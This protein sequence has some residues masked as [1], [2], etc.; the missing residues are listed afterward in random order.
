[1]KWLQKPLHDTM[2]NIDHILK[3]GMVGTSDTC[4]DRCTMW[5][6]DLSFIRVYREETLENLLA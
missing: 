3:Q 2:S 6:K 5:T 4:D 1:M